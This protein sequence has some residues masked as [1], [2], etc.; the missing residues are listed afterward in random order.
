[1]SIAGSHHDII[2]TIL[3][4]LDFPKLYRSYTWK[5]D[6]WKRGFPDLFRLEQEISQAARKRS[7]RKEHLL[8]LAKWGGLRNTKRI[9]CPRSIRI[10]L[11]HRGS[12]AP[13]LLRDPAKA[14]DLLDIQV[15][16]FGPT[17][18]SKVLHFGVPQV[19]GALDTRLVRTFGR[20]DEASQRYPLLNLKVTRT[21]PSWAV[22]SQQPGW[23]DEYGTWTYALN[24]MAES[25]NDQQIPCPHPK[26][27]VQANLRENGVWLPADVE[28]A[29]FSFASRETGKK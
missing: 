21:G 10:N 11:Y 7:I 8:A 24:L 12:P 23:P 1:M 9:S 27:F 18:S 29:L 16:G 3:Q 26:R 19:F 17:Y 25:L 2:D 5:E 6:T 13:W 20:G 4:D 22:Y 28:T 15:I 14:I